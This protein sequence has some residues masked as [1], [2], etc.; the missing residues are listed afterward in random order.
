MTIQI[1]ATA[2]PSPAQ[3]PILAP[4]SLSQ[5]TSLIVMFGGRISQKSERSGGA[6]EQFTRGRGVGD[7]VP[8]PPREHWS[9]GTL[10]NTTVP[11]SGTSKKRTPGLLGLGAL[12]YPTLLSCPSWGCKNLSVPQFLYL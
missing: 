12:D 10:I 5:P 9:Q 8:G 6:V 4:A 7:T 1:S 11:L 3:V 2:V